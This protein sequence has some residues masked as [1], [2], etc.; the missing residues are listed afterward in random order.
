MKVMAFEQEA[1]DIIEGIGAAI[2]ATNEEVVGWALQFYGYAKVIV[3]GGLEVGVIKDGKVV[4][5]MVLPFKSQVLGPRNKH[6]H[7]RLVK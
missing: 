4:E 6:P 1:I 3:E 2:G 7:L 5:V